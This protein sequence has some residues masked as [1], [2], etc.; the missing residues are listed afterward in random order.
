MP[1]EKDIKKWKEII[2]ERYENYLKT[3]FYFKDPE[4][5]ASFRSAL[6]NYGLLKGPF[7]EPAY[8]FK[9]GVSACDLAEKYFPGQSEAL[10][11]ALLSDPLYAHQENSICA[12]HEDR[13][14]VVVA[15]GTASGK[16]EAFLYPVLFDLYRQHL[17]GRLDDPGVRAM[18]LYPMNALANDQRRRLGDICELLQKAGSDFAPT[19]GQYI[20]QTPKN[21]SDKSQNAS[22]R[23]EERLCGESVFRE[24][25]RE[26]PPHILLTNYSMLEY[27]LIRPDDSPLFDK[28]RGFHWQFIV[29]DEAHQYR[30]AK[31]MEMGMLLR[32]L[33]QRLRE[34]G[35]KNPFLCIATSATIVSGGGEKDR[36]VVSDFAE[37]LFDEPFTERDVVFGK[38]EEFSD[39]S[40]G[41][42]QRFHI[43]LRALE[44]AF[45]LHR[46]DKDEVVLNRERETRG[47]KDAVP[48]EIALCREC[49]QHYYVGRCQDGVL[50]EAVRDPSQTGFGV[51][52]Y[53]P[54]ETEKWTHLLCRRCGELST[55][56]LS[57]DCNAGIAVEKCPSHKE[58]RDQLKECAS[59]NYRRGG[60]GDPVHEIV[61]GS[62]GPNTVIA[63]ALHGLLPED[64][65]KVLAFADSRQEAAFFAWY[66]ED[67][68]RKLRDRNLLLHAIR[69]DPDDSE[70]LSVNDL[71]SRL[72]KQWNSVGLF[73]KSDTNQTKNEKVFKAILGEALTDER[74]LSLAGVGLVKWFVEI[75][76]DLKLP[77]L[78]R[79][80]P[81]N[82]SEEE[83]LQL[84]SYLLDELRLQ[85][86]MDLPNHMGM[87]AWNEVCG[88]PQQS[89]CFG[90]P[91]KRKN[92]KEWGA[93]SSAV[94]KHFLRRILMGS[95]L[96]DSEK[97]QTA[98]DLMKEIWKSIVREYDTHKQEADRI[99]CPVLSKGKG[100]TFRLNSRWL[101]IR[102]AGREE[103]FECNTCGRVSAHN[104]RDV[105]P[106]NGCPGSLAAIDI[107]RLKENHY[108]V[109]YE[110]SDLPPAMSAEEHTAQIESD[111]ARR[112]Q[113]Q[114][115]NGDINLL[116]SSTTFEVGVDL[117]DLE[118]VF[119]RNV[120]PESFNYT[121]RAGR[122]GR[123]ET[124]GLVVTYC[125]R[126]PHDLYHYEEPQKR[127][128]K[129]EV[130][131]PRLH[132][133][134]EK[135]V[136]RHMVA[137]ALS[138]FFKREEHKERFEN[139]KSL[140]HDWHGPKAVSD[141]RKFCLANPNLK[142]SL[143]RIV[144]SS[145]MIEKVGLNSDV[146]I[147]KICG[148]ESRF[149]WVQEDVCQDYR[150]M[151]KLR[152]ECF[153]RGD[154]F[155]S[156]LIGRRMKTIAGESTLTFLS[157]NAV[158]P[159]YGFPVDVV[160]LDTRPGRFKS[161]AVSLQRDLSQ[162]IAEYAPASKVVAN[163]L[164]WES[165]GVKIV[166]GKRFPVKHYSYD[167]ARNFRQWGEN[168]EPPG[169]KYLSP[170][171]GFVTPLFDKPKEPSRRTSR[172]YTTRPFFKGFDKREQPKTTELFGVFMTQALPGS[173]VVLCEGKDKRGFH[174]CLD[175]GTHMVEKNG[176]HKTPENSDCRG[177][178][179]RYSLGHEMVTD[180]MR[181][182]FPELIFQWDAYSLG[183]AVL[184][185]AAEI[186]NVPDTDLNITITGSEE[187]EESD[188]AAIVLYDN[189]PGGAG[190]VVQ[191]EQESMFCA[192]IEK[193]RERVQGNCKCDSSCY[194][195]LRSY[196]N[197]FAHP[198]LDRKA[199]LR[200]LNTALD[201]G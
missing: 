164:E 122:A 83:S 144:P 198:H 134:N 73:N 185:G 111:I 25:M 85:S 200:F 156:G 180:V 57:C 56:E 106:R 10:L 184:L 37:S 61:H 174:I 126:N 53:L 101:R 167:D 197:Q 30:G 89:Y 130:R 133:N 51:D 93:G 119:L 42:V 148:E 165:C 196:R 136:L 71:R 118:V 50:E 69:K 96:S 47:D 127:V 112:R 62:D 124:P 195:C 171:F 120:P 4:L 157:R 137:E 172:L 3:S 16:T 12:V 24:D 104:V 6:R 80:P 17:D 2:F 153:D 194:G 70:G 27:L 123:R 78:M 107:G 145:Q 143:R 109:L 7:P 75:P 113:E 22:M 177:N 41:G 138:A 97:I 88:R 72:V 26:N 158:I 131:P 114:F 149:D 189:V 108:R 121:Q 59:C 91:G 151:E 82:L 90:P 66:A 74:R 33:K 139:V 18:V 40:N 94:V 186:L 36:R 13:R 142:E 182:Q 190:L 15:T 140:M 99:F 183:Y 29:L 110:S 168:E 68:Y 102:L 8:D 155:N 44:G 92:I 128:I 154:D 201:R 60:I 188:E 147:D 160:E 176:D 54:S 34:G 152:Q 20:G 32:R 28:G 95:G 116:S 21:R 49:G 76:D 150:N 9:K 193:A 58:H 63:T 129:G 141:L 65:R 173:L 67:S 132:M 159:K 178:M 125:R 23:L 84:M 162:A 52:Y 105:C 86:A 55:D 35:R 187:S 146:W 87:P 163:K 14:N 115:K 77:A 170:V 103:I 81:W 175:C 1:E 39:E 100:G 181:L 43:F 45:L 166:R 48:L 38:Y 179:K 161:A 169:K 192:M 19:F 79:L 46:N 11:P 191:L 31:G 117:G 98:V 199:A 5:R 135:I 64:G